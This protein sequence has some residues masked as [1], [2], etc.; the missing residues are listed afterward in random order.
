MDNF[1]IGLLQIAPAATQEGN[2]GKGL[3][4]CGRAKA[5]GCDLVLF[6]EMWN[7]GYVFSRDSREALDAGSP[8]VRAFQEQAGNLEMAVALTYLE[9]V[10][11]G[12]RNTVTVFDRTG[13]NI[14]TYA[15]VHTCDFG[16]DACLIPGNEFTAAVLDTGRGK[17]TIGAMICYDR[18][19]PE[20][21]RILMLKGAELILIPNACP[22]GINRKSQLRSR[23]FE[24][25]L[26]VAMANY[27]A[28]RE[29]CNGHSLA[30]DGIAYDDDSP[31]CGERDM[32]LTEA[33]EAE[34]IYTAEFNMDKLAEYR[35]REV[36]GNAYRRPGR[37][38][39]L[40]SEEVKQPFIRRDARR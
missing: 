12:T 37:Y 35:K 33:G 14:L 39:L 28:D 26:G 27:P 2:L 25:M 17:I 9:A 21:A 3:D 31:D 1:K 8:F 24:N 13:K 32:L 4:Y 16:D 10:P 40:C 20:S 29:D 5:L 38:S 6:P 15:K 22:I 19:F 18:E 11:G 30:F 23:A 36:W 34:G 7:T